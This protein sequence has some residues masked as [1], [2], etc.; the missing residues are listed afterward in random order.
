MLRLLM[1]PRCAPEIQPP[2]CRSHAILAALANMRL[3]VLTID[4]GR[5]F[6]G[7]GAD[8]VLGGEGDDTLNGVGKGDELCLAVWA[9]PMTDRDGRESLSFQSIDRLVTIFVK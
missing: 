4:N 1:N 3:S 7:G 8:T 9:S 5:V 6:A 2:N